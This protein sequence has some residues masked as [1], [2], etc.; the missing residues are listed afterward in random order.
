MNG[1]E[2]WLVALLTSLGMLGCAD[3]RDPLSPKVEEI[4]LNS[5][6]AASSVVYSNFGPNLAF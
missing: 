6:A 4:R 3:L 2:R 5:V 1:R